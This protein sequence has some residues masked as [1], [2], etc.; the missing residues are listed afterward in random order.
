MFPHGVQ[1]VFGW[2]GGHGFKGTMQYFVK[3]G[4]PAPL[5]RP[6]DHGRVPRSDRPGP[7][8]LTWLAA[9]GVAAVMLVSSRDPTIS[10]AFNREMLTLFGRAR[11]ARHAA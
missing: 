9:L 1:K 2:F 5:A 3:S 6:R 7:W 11:G 4:I 10:R 8:L